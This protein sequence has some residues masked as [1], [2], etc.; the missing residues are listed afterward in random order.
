MIWLW[1]TDWLSPIDTRKIIFLFILALK[2]ETTTLFRNV[3]KRL[4]NDTASYPRKKKNVK[5]GPPFEIWCV[6]NYKIKQDGRDPM[7][8]SHHNYVKHKRSAQ[9]S[10]E[11][12]HEWQHMFESSLCVFSLT[13]IRRSDYSYGPGDWKWLSPLSYL[14]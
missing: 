10:P 9:N 5:L 2:Y 3:G 12:L 13:I 14:K 11:Y 4:A 6:Y 7:Y 8:V 1:N